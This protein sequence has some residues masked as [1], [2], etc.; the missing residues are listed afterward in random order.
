MVFKIDQK[1][2]TLDTVKPKKFAKQNGTVVSVR[3]RIGEIGVWLG[4]FDGDEKPVTTWFRP[5]ELV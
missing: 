3:N 2:K 4:N 1:V 5:S